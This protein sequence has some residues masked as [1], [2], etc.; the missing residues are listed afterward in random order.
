[1][2]YGPN[3][4]WDLKKRLQAQCGRESGVIVKDPGGCTR[5]ALI[6]PNPYRVGMG[7]LAVHTLYRL[8]N[9]RPDILCERAFL[10][11]RREIPQYERTKTPLLTLE[12]QRPVNDFDV[13][14]L[15]ISF[16]ND[17][18][19]L[20]ILFELIGLPLR[21][22]ERRADAPLIIAGG[23]APTLNPLPLAQIADAVCLGEAEA[24][25]EGLFPLLAENVGREQ[26]IEALAECPGVFVPSAEN[27]PPLD[28]RRYTADLDAWPT[29]TVVHSD[30]AEFGDMHLIEISRGC[31]RACRFCATPAL[32][33]PYRHRR[34]AA[35][36][37]MVETGLHHRQRFGLIGADLLSHPEFDAIVEQ[38]RTSGATFSL[39]SVRAADVDE[40]IAT[41]LATIGQHSI[42]LGI[43]AG[44]ERLRRR[45]AKGL[46]DKQIIDAAT[47]L[48]RAG[49]TRLRL[50]FMIGLPHETNEDVDAIVDLATRIRDTVR[51]CAPKGPRTTDVSLTIAPFVP[52]P[53]TPFA[54][55]TFAGIDAIKMKLKRIEQAVTPIDGLGVHADAP[56]QAAVEAILSQ[57]GDE[58]IAFLEAAHRDGVRRA[59]AATNRAP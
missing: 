24:F 59:L 14:A 10:P 8:L 6:S 55:E 5:V 40:R 21:A 28:E 46:T 35:V 41:L 20:P 50:Y 2:I 56:Q 58:A 42:A 17:L 36:A 38:I 12:S 9:D 51:G 7:N 26:S 57:A 13:I 49:I 52:K 47:T 16:E 37:A 22:N 18:L 23:A 3:M 15:T 29:Q 54:E 19:N 25:A 31:P 45:L 1:M 44:S 33:A 53:H 43:E 34:A 48:A 4:S 11:D 30:D 39:S 32:Y 27:T